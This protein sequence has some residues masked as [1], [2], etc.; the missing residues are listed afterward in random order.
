MQCWYP[1]L[2][3]LFGRETAEL[4]TQ[5][6]D[7]RRVPDAEVTKKYTITQAIGGCCAI[8]P[9]FRVYRALTTI[10][11]T[12]SKEMIM[13]RFLSQWNR[14]RVITAVGIIVGCGSINSII[15][16]RC[17]TSIPGAA[18]YIGIHKRISA[19]M[20]TASDQIR[21]LQRCRR[22][23]AHEAD[24]CIRLKKRERLLVHDPNIAATTG[25]LCDMTA[26]KTSH[27][28]RQG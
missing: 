5:Q 3:V 22:Q 18:N 20:S 19:L 11:E 26:G 27:K 8:K 17:R 13:N 7:E 9:Q 21:Q 28:E 14:A 2:D 23:E 6:L 24:M 25:P 15:P 16:I 4:S 1:G 12:F 10:T